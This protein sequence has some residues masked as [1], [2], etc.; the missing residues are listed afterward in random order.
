MAESPRI[1]IRLTDRQEA[2]MNRCVERQGHRYRF[3][4]SSFI[5]EAVDSAIA[6]SE[7]EAL[8][9]HHQDLD[10]LIHHMATLIADRAVQL[11]VD[12]AKHEKNKIDIA[13][14][15]AKMLKSASKRRRK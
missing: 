3:T 2:E 11:L 7:I 14:R 6:R 12:R 10:R 5:S 1:T 13:E 15:T 9:P 8:Y 4:Q